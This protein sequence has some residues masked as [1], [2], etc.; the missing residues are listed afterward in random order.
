[1]FDWSWSEYA[2]CSYFLS[3]CSLRC[4]LAGLMAGT[5]PARSAPS[6]GRA[7]A[8]APGRSC[9]RGRSGDTAVAVDDVATV[10]VWLPVAVDVFVD[11][12]PQFWESMSSRELTTR[13]YETSGFPLP[14]N[15]AVAGNKNKNQLRISEV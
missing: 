2:S 15:K 13:R 8:A 6:S 9:L 4:R 7:G 14:K 1:M 5:S 11:D 10:T 3:A 12:A